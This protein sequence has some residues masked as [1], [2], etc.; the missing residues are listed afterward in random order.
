[1]A[2]G[3]GVEASTSI[4]STATIASLKLASPVPPS[5][6]SHRAIGA[7][8]GSARANAVEAIVESERA[9]QL[10]LLALLALQLLGCMRSTRLK[11]RPGSCH[12][13]GLGQSQGQ[14]QGQC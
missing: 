9:F 1:M 3:R 14:D 7:S 10:L 11:R 6:D 2:V 12:G 5:P 13:R 8:P 4:P